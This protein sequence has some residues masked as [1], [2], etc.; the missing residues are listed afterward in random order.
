MEKKGFLHLCSV[1]LCFFNILFSL[2]LINGQMLNKAEGF[3]KMLLEVLRCQLKM[4]SSCKSSELRNVDFIIRCP[5]FTYEGANRYTLND[6]DIQWQ[7][8]TVNINVS[9]VCDFVKALS[10]SLTVYIF[11]GLLYLKHCWVRFE[12]RIIAAHS[13][14]YSQGCVS[15][16]VKNLISILAI[17]II[18]GKKLAFNIWIWES[19]ILKLL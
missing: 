18:A 19:I 1:L 12:K 16:S 10:P 2:F 5:P 17:S 4:C 13:S 15:I 6:L 8:S 14:A 9:Q 7:R 11:C 3:L